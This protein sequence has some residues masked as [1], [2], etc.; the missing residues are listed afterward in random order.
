MGNLVI[1]AIPEEQDRVWKI[2][3]EKVPHLTLLF[4]GDEANADTQQIVQFVEHAVT[5][6]EHGPFYLDVE[7]RGTLGPDEA[8]VLFFSKRSWNLKWIRQFRGQ[9]LQNQAVKTAFDSTQQYDEWTPH[10]TMGYPTSPAKEDKEDYPFYSVC[11]DRIAVWDQD[12]AGPEFQLEWPDRELE[13]DL[14]IAYSD[15]QKH[16]LMHGAKLGPRPKTAE[17]LGAEFLEHHGVKGMKWGVRKDVKGSSAQELKVAAFGAG[18]LLSPKFRRYTSG[19]TKL[20]VGLFGQYALLSPGVRVDLRQASH[21]VAADKADTKWEK[22]IRNGTAFVEVH[23]AVSAHFNKGIGAVN[24]KHPADFS[25]DTSDFNNRSSWGPKYTAYRKEVDK[26]S[27][28]SIKKAADEMYL[29]SPSGKHEAVVE[30]DPS[31]I[32][33]HFQIRVK[34]LQ[35]A[36][37]DQTLDVVINYTIDSGGKVTG[38]E[39]PDDVNAVHSAVERGKEFVAHQSVLDNATLAEQIKAKVQSI[40]DDVTGDPDGD[41]GLFGDPLIRTKI[42]S[43]LQDFYKDPNVDNQVVYDALG[44]AFIE[45]YGVKGMHWGVRKDQTATRLSTTT[46]HSLVR[47]KAKIKVEGGDHHKAHPDAV[48]VA[49]AKQKLKKSGTNALSNQELR[50]VANRV[51]LENQVHLLTS[52]KGRKYVGKILESEGQNLLRTGIREG[53]RRGVKRAGATAAVAALA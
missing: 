51:Q 53:V 20:K 7:R 41:V 22:G 26:L 42:Q 44:Q 30:P 9:L 46:G 3:S 21:K 47:G 2:S 24:A 13:G 25:K 49:K 50:D 35:H 27:A 18:A 15:Y 6:A 33:G 28:R 17:E 36:A 32:P 39:L 31:G 23:N 34:Q 52:H 1:V 43:V 11:F 37:T 12:Y 4:L 38:F 19:D 14:A 10:L 8:D 40:L 45:H 29:Q 5:L 48:R 16:A